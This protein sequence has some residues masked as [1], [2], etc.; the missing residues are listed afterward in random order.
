MAEYTVKNPRTNSRTIGKVIV[1]AGGETVI[2]LTEARALEEIDAGLI[3][4]EIAEKADEKKPRG[5]PAKS[6]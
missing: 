1:P 5:R 2:E 3:V 6:E 4:E